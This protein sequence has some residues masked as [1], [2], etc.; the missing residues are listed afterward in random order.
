M[1]DEESQT[2]L[3]MLASVAQQ[4][5]AYV[6]KAL[7]QRIRQ[8][9]VAP[10]QYVDKG[11]MATIGRNKAVVD[12]RQFSFGGFFAWI[13]WLFVHLMLLID[14][15]NRIIV[16]MNWVWSYI[17]FDRGTRLIVRKYPDKS[18]G[19]NEHSHSPID[20]EVIEDVNV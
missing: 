9:P 19:S 1:F 14:F 13:T 7:I 6:A 16:L 17:N 4:Q 3:P 11:T 5:G 12:L 10:F 20:K 15:R 18:S 2:E 8:Q